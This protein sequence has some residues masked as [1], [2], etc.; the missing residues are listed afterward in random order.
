MNLL[1]NVT[2]TYAVRVLIAALLITGIIDAQLHD[3]LS[4]SFDGNY[5]QLEIGGPYVGAEFH[6]SLPFPSRIS[7][8][9]PVANSIEM[10]SD[11]WQRGNQSHPFT[12]LLT[13]DGIPELIGRKPSTYTWTP[14][15]A[16]FELDG[17][18][19]TGTVTYKFTGSLPVMAVIIEIENPDPDER[20]FELFINIDTPLRTSHTYRTVN[21]ARIVALHDNG[22]LAFFDDEDTDSTVVFVVNAGSTPVTWN[23]AGV[24]VNG[25]ASIEQ[26]ANPR[27]GFGYEA[28]LSGNEKTEIVLIIGSCRSGEAE[29]II[30]ESLNSW[31]SD[32]VAFERKIADYLANLGR[33]SV[34]DETLEHTLNWSKSLLFSNTHY[35][36]GYY[37]PMP[38]PA[39]YNFYFTH[40]VLLTDLGVVFFDPDRVR[41][42]L[43]FLLSLTREDSV[44]AHA[45][46]WKD[47]AYVTEYAGPDNWNNLWFVILAASYLKH[48]GDIETVNQLFPVMSKSIRLV[49]Q[50]LEDDLMY[51]RQPDWWD[52]GNVYGAR[53]YLTILTVQGLR[54]YGYV[55][56]RIDARDTDIEYYNGL[57]A[58]MQETLT[59][60]FW[61]DDR[62]YLM[63]MLDRQTRDHHFYSGSLLAGVFNLLENGKREILLETARKELLD[64]NLGIR[65][66][67]P[68]DF[69]ELI[70]VY[71]FQGMEAGEPYVYANGGV[72]PH[73]TA[74]YVLGLISAGKPD[75]ALHAMKR[76]HTIDGIANSPGGQPSFFEYRNANRESI[77]YGR[78]DKPTFLWAGG[79]FANMLYRL[80]GMRENT[81]NIYF[82]PE[83]PAD[84]RRIE[85][86][87]YL[88]GR[89]VEVLYSGE[90][91]FFK[92]IEFD[93]I[94]GYSAIPD[95]PVS[96]IRFM[97]GEPD[98]P[99]LAEV[100]AILTGITYDRDE[101]HMTITLG[102]LN[103]SSA[104]LNLISP[105][106]E[107]SIQQ[108]GM[109]NGIQTGEKAGRNTYR[110]LVPV[111]F[112][113]DTETISL[114]FHN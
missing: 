83:L 53:V 42:D 100:D 31:Q 50:N 108:T 49:L 82:S 21:S 24:N 9:Y 2:V 19:Y 47:G 99:Y 107:A 38:C 41:R 1:Y 66:A 48:T 34:G 87:T 57:A 32:A 69:H 105:F 91:N 37:L 70:D 58:R 59:R 12:V 111:G 74:W 98:Y 93:G 17:E 61:D 90:G 77:Y 4:R 30:D 29:R 62:G 52:I 14:Y 51:S 94:T 45:Y 113:N 7:F 96:S 44:L 97:R 43:L 79:W 35:L 64:E 8:Y 27:A 18:T 39:E 85:Y 89:K 102:G 13:V 92:Q 25:I 22:Y 40:D 84:F 106:P 56:H 80:M 109:D 10:S 15:S 33:V 65:N 76:Y 68:A 95:E 86:E 26:S 73:G 75:D 11:Y 104:V 72:W 5:G 54:S 114:R 103:G 110:F 20:L 55:A 23:A 16:R 60:E 71:G 67:M 28:R 78:I 112:T 46:Y 63:S 36:D 3:P 6:H 88:N 101:R 81:S